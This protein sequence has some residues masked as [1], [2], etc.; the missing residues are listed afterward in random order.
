[1]IFSKFEGRGEDSGVIRCAE[2]HDSLAVL[3]DRWLFG[4]IEPCS[5]NG[6]SGFV[7]LSPR[8]TVILIKKL[9]KLSPKGSLTTLTVGFTERELTFTVCNIGD[10]DLYEIA[11]LGILAGFDCHRFADGLELSRTVH[12]SDAM[13]IYAVKPAELKR[14]FEEYF[15]EDTPRE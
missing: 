9:A 11:R 8:A 13:K 10:D 15:R 4:S 1:M 5:E 12:Q 14:L 6:V 2:L 7:E 3:F